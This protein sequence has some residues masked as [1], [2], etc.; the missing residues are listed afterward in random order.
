LT[1]YSVIAGSISGG[2]ATA[3]GWI[4]GG[5]LTYKFN[6]TSGAVNKGDF[7]YVGNTQKVIAGAGSTN[8]SSA[9]WIRTKNTGADPGDDAIGNASTAGFLA[10]AANTAGGIGVFKGTAVTATTVPIDA[11]FYGANV[12]NAFI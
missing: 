10:G 9:K 12:G 1:P 5:A 8:I 11:I 6:L 2:Q 3:N 4:A 7:F